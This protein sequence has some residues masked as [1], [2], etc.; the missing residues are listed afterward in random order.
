MFVQ[1]LPSAPDS[2]L[3]PLLTLAEGGTPMELL[4]LICLL[5]LSH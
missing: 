5:T 1:R 3:C 4:V 2:I